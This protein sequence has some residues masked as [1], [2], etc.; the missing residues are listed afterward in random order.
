[1]KKQQSTTIKEP[2]SLRLFFSSKWFWIIVTCVII[3]FLVY[4]GSRNNDP[5]TNAKNQLGLPSDWRQISETDKSGSSCVLSDNPCPSKQ[6]IF[7]PR[8]FEDINPQF[9]QVY[10]TMTNEH[11]KFDEKCLGLNCGN[12]FIHAH[13]S[14]V[15]V[16]ISAQE[17]S[18]K[19]LTIY[20]DIE[21]N[22][23]NYN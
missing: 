2:S 3:G 22:Q 10:K 8:N 21:K 23:H 12:D 4:L 15:L 1:M 5:L 6:Y 7:S 18:D 11:Y 20:V 9:T 13:N 16:R 14:E 19:K 17:G